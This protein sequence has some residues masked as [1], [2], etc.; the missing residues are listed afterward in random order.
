[1]AHADVSPGDVEGLTT[2]VGPYRI[3][4]SRMA[5]AH[6]L[7]WSIS[8]LHT[9]A[10][11]A[12]DGSSRPPLATGPWVAAVIAGLWAQSDAVAEL[13]RRNVELLALQQLDIRYLGPVHGDDLIHARCAVRSCTAG[14]DGQTG[15]LTV[16]DACFDAAER[17]LLSVTRT[18][19]CARILA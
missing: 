12:E 6:S 7:I 18:Y 11:R 10:G 3:S 5:V 15:S 2:T 8:E 1:M 9:L 13:R 4:W 19:Q 14:D 17:P 16:E